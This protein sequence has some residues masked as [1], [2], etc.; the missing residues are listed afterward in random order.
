MS[1]P[2]TPAERAELI[3][4]VAL[5]CRILG[6]EELTRAAFGHVSARLGPDLV[7]IKSRGPDEEALE[8]TTAR[9]IITLTADGE[10]VEAAPGLAPANESLIHLALL[11]AR[12]E[13]GS[14]VHIHPPHV[15]ALGAAGRQL[16]PM[17]GAFDP[18]GLR[19]ALEGVPVFPR[20][21]LISTP[22]LAA[23]MVATMAGHDACILRGHGIVTCG[24]TVETAVLTAIVLAELAKLNWLAASV[25][26]PEPIP[27]EDLPEWQK[28]FAKHGS[29]P[30]G[31]RSDTGAPSEWHFYARRDAARRRAA[32]RE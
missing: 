24:P 20:T 3:E 22:E 13:I 30:F 29:R 5:G 10:V 2:S 26:E 23:E 1:F 4:K 16:V 8:F 25:G 31:G 18:S 11:K 19:L 21:L 15:V 27:A 17:F 28:F 12:P 6:G 7:A 32:G 9:D 14:V